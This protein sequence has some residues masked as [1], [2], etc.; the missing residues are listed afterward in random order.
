MAA[1]RRAAAR[2]LDHASTGRH[3]VVA[4]GAGGIGPMENPLA[5]AH[6]SFHSALSSFP[7]AAAF[8]AAA[9]PEWKFNL[10]F[11]ELFVPLLLKAETESIL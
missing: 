1:R 8:A 4:E 3:T 6:A 7:S 9:L 10:C 11:N 5:D 2:F